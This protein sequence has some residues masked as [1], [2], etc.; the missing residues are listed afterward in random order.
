[1]ATANGAE[2][3]DRDDYE[4]IYGVVE[5]NATRWKADQTTIDEV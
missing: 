3:S 5:R 4:K 1:M 2:A